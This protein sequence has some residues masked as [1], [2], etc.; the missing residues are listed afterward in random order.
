[1][2]GLFYKIKVDRVAFS[3]NSLPFS[4]PKVQ[5]MDHL[6]IPLVVKNHAKIVVNLKIKNGR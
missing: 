2:I 4:M 6:Q 3:F 1:M 5:K